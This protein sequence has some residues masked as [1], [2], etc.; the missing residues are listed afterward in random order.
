MRNSVEI[1]KQVNAISE[2]RTQRQRKVFVLICFSIVAVEWLMALITTPGYVIP[3][4]NNSIARLVIFG[5]LVWQGFGSLIFIRFSF[6]PD[7]WK[8]I[9]QTLIYFL[10]FVLPALPI[11]FLGPP[12]ETIVIA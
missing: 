10:V 12:I 2:V 1:V 5:I 6:G 8:V 3:F 11:F 9:V 4:V 7:R